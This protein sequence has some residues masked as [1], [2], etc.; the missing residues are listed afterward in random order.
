MVAV[1]ARRGGERGGIRA[2]AGFGEAQREYLVTRGESGQP[3]ALDVFGCMARD[4]SADHPDLQKQGHA[5]VAAAEFLGG[6]SRHRECSLAA[7]VGGG[8]AQPGDSERS[9]FAHPL[10]RKGV[11]AVPFLEIGQ[12]ALKRIAP[13]RFRELLL[14]FIKCEIHCPQSPRR[15]S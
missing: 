3:L 2:D 13:H 8:H 12:Q 6:D 1:T 4:A 9:E 14:L 7:A 15:N 10:P 5:D 11:A